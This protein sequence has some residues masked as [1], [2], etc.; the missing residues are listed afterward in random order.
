MDEVC[1]QQPQ[2]YITMKVTEEESKG[3]NLNGKCQRLKTVKDGE[4]MR[5]TD[6]DFIL[7]K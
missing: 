4:L 3:G 5:R 1:S 2:K 6:V 7:L